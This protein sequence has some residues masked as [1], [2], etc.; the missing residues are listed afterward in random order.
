MLRAR[1]IGEQE[2][3]AWGRPRRELP[4]RPV[5]RLAHT[6]RSSALFSTLSQSRAAAALTVPAPGDFQPLS[7]WRLPPGIAP[8]G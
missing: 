4:E 6:L 8:A 2:P 7:P 5:F 3:N 1:D